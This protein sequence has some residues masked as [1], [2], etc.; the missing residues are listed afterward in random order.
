MPFEEEVLFRPNSF[1]SVRPMSPATKQLIAEAIERDLS[2]V[3]VFEL[4]EFDRFHP[5]DFT[6]N[7]V[8]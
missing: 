4:K 6:Q 7:A 3:Q 5:V 2:T 8:V 1:F